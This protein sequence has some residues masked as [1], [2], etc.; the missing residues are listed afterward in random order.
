R[1]AATPPFG[2]R[3][4]TCR[5]PDVDEAHRES[6][7]LSAAADGLTCARTDTN[8]P[9]ATRRGVTVTVRRGSTVS[10]TV[11]D[12]IWSPSIAA[13]SRPPLATGTVAANEPSA[14]LVTV[15]AVVQPRSPARRSSIATSEPAG[16]ATPWTR[17]AWP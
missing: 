9:T 4:P 14:P 2:A 6:V 3:A 13:R 10:A 1:K 5:Q 17:A 11:A 15:V 16:A 7:S 12:R 8:R